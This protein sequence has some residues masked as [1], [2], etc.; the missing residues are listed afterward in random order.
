MFYDKHLWMYTYTWKNDGF[1]FLECMDGIL[2]ELSH[3]IWAH[4][5]LRRLSLPSS[6]SWIVR[7]VTFKH[8]MLLEIS[9]KRIHE[10][11][12]TQK[13]KMQEDHSLRTGSHQ[14]LSS[15]STGFCYSLE[16]KS[17]LTLRKPTDCIPPG[18]SVQ[19][20][21]QARILEWVSISSSRES[22]G[23][24]DRTCP[25]SALADRFFTTEPPGKPPAGFTLG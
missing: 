22:F 17:C 18:S 23:P 9:L 15:K 7:F 25:S 24:R 13:G 11:K 14:G 8:T 20:I 3:G 12:R 19:G 21:S 1:S 6:K 4:S 5:H 10:R 16:D 2:L